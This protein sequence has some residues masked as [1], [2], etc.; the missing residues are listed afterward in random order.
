MSVFSIMKRRQG[1]E[2]KISSKQAG[3]QKQEVAPPSKYRHV[4]THA[5]ADALLG[6]PAGWMRGDAER[7]RESNQKRI[8]LAL[9]ASESRLPQSSSS[10]M[11][12]PLHINIHASGSSS[13][14]S[15]IR[16]YGN[17]YTHSSSRRNSQYRKTIAA[18]SASPSANMHMSPSFNSLDAELYRARVPAAD[19]Q[20]S[21]W[22]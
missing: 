6:A 1:K 13:S 22:L 9:S 5:A 15:S 11:L 3:K 12:S 17:N 4:P 7:I 14:A 21:R 10:S 20:D 8:A 18:T 16:N 19:A 2:D